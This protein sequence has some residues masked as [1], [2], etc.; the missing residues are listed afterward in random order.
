MYQEAVET[1]AVWAGRGVAKSVDRRQFRLRIVG[2]GLNLAKTLVGRRNKAC[3]E[4]ANK[5]ALCGLGI[6]PRDCVPIMMF[7]GNSITANP[8]YRIVSKKQVELTS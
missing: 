7:G 1:E 3:G 6:Y 2:V 5:R 8:T 4:S